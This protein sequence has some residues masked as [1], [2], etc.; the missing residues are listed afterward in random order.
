MTLEQ[1]RQ[2]NAQ[3]KQQMQAA[4]MNI[5]FVKLANNGDTIVVKLIPPFNGYMRLVTTLQGDKK[6]KSHY[7][8]HILGDYNFETGKYL[9]NPPIELDVNQIRELN[10]RPNNARI[11]TV[12][13]SAEQGFLRETDKGHSILQIRRDGI[14]RDTKTTYNVINAAQIDDDDWK[15]LL[16]KVTK[17]EIAELQREETWDGISK[18]ELNKLENMGLK[19]RN[20]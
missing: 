19:E 18:D 10:Q 5:S 12:P 16:P 20:D 14:A 2:L 8:M 9:S 6:L 17:E 1:I 13:F 7:R 4:S 3:R 15:Y 11:W